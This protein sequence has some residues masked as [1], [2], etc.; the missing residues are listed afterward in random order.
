M[1]NVTRADVHAYLHLAAAHD[2]QPEVRLYSFER[3]NDALV[4]LKLGRG[5]GAKVIAIAAPPHS[6][7]ADQPAREKDD[8]AAHDHLER[9]G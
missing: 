4:D 2:L 8:H 6:A 3:A 1:A 7:G 9:G 5:R